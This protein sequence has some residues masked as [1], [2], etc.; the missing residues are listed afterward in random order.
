VK[1]TIPVSE[2]QP[3]TAPG[4]G[5]TDPAPGAGGG[6]LEIQGDAGLEGKDIEHAGDVRITGSVCHGSTVR[7][8]GDLHVGG[9]IE[10]AT[11]I[12]A[13]SLV[14]LGG[15][16][17]RAKGRYVAGT[18]LSC[19][20]ANSATLE[21]GENIECEVELVNCNVVCRGVL[22]AERAT[23]LGGR[24]TANAGVLCATLGTPGGGEMTVEAGLDEALLAM[25]AERAPLIEADSRRAARIKG[26][27]EPLMAQLRSLTSK[28]RETATEL[29]Y[30]AGEMQEKADATVNELRELLNRSLAM[31]VSEITVHGMV[32][33]GVLIRFRQAELLITK[34][35]KGPLKISMEGSAAEARMVATDLKTGAATVLQSVRVANARMSTLLKLIAAKSGPEA[36]HKAA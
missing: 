2:Q 4:R 8:G 33:P 15:I 28:Q 31:G 5:T 17:G 3:V 21:A 27:V 6:P 29:L 25:A 7:V 30:Q 1:E 32:H 24:I 26:Q 35:I 13:R 16:S 12:A 23:L 10:L 18:F 9:S 36:T 34:T 14:A 11:V 22:R 19:R 20:S